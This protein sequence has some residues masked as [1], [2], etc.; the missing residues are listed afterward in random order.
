MYPLATKTGFKTYKIIAIV[1]VV[2]MV[3]GAAWLGLS[4]R[5]TPLAHAIELIRAGKA[6]FAV[7][8]LEDLSHQH[9][10]DPSVFPWLAQGYLC[11]E[12]LGEGRTALDTALRLSLP[13]SIV[14]PVVLA[15]AAY[16][17]KQGDF[18]EAQNLFDSAASVLSG[19]E[20]ADGQASL[21]CNWA[22]SEARKGNL[23]QTASILEKGYKRVATENEALKTQL[24]HKLSQYYRELAASYETKGKNDQL[25]LEFLS[26]S[27]AIVE[28]PATQMAI[29]N[30]YVRRGKIDLAAKSYEAVCLKDANNLEARH[31]L[32]ELLVQKKDL[33]AA[34]AALVELIDKEKSPE[35]FQLLAFLDE[36]LANQA[37]AVRA[38]EDATNL[39]AKDPL[40]LQQLEKALTNWS[41][42]LSQQGKT[43]E[44]LSVKGHKE[45]VSEQLMS[46]LKKDR[47]LNA[48]DEKKSDEMQE[49]EAST[50]PGE[51]KPTILGNGAT[52]IALCFS[53][54]WL[55]KGSLTPEGEIK[56]KNISGKPITDLYLTV[57]FY[58][59]TLRMRNSSIV[60]PVVSAASPNFAQGELRTLY[61]SC[62]NIV[63]P[64]HQLAVIIFWKGRLLK[65]LPVVKLH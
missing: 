56:I 41:L 15:Y 38:L 13:A 63:K 43:Q 28:E 51:F 36:K 12:R 27:L 34:Q 29:A 31:R 21:F 35:N 26:K 48:E 64:D 25:A 3:I 61:F 22:D 10:D 19:N 20:L 11:T 33:A 59:N 46:L 47:V 39:R 1:V 18:E 9:P 49:T 17:E 58:D 52:P 14:M 24:G 6:A 5:K 54:I 2:V 45:R 32:I 16:Y 50:D 57:V 53:R 23:V 40:L 30:I 37:G 7:P 62:P 60:L 65:E 4:N 44:S 42:V 55:A 8:I